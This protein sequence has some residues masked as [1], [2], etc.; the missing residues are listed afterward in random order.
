MEAHGGLAQCSILTVPRLLS[1]SP[2]S[3]LSVVSERGGN[4]LDPPLRDQGFSLG[5]FDAFH[6]P[7]YLLY[8]MIGATVLRFAPIWPCARPAVTAMIFRRWLLIEAVIFF[9]RGFSVAM[10]SV[11]QPNPDCVSTATGSVWWEGLRLVFGQ[12]TTCGDC[13]FSGHTAAVTLLALIWTHYSRGEEFAVCCGRRRLIT[14]S[15]DAAGDPMG[16]KLVDFFVWAYAIMVY[17]FII[18]TRFHY[19]SDVFIGFTITY[20]FFRYYHFYIVSSKCCHC[21]CGCCCVQR[22]LS[23]DLPVRLLTFSYVA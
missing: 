20:F 4:R 23:S 10:T 12:T 7:D 15:T 19:S 22:T 5:H 3:V 17:Y 1:C 2:P 14:A 13:M 9:F 11:P 18:T 21:G 6:L 8:G 16:W